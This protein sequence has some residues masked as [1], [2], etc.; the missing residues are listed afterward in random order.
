[1]RSSVDASLRVFSFDVQR[2]SPKPA[3][4]VRQRPSL[5]TGLPRRLQEERGSLV[6]HDSSNQL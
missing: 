4:A 6:R 2:K 3:E 1:M 5:E